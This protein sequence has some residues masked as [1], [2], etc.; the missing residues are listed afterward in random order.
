MKKRLI[1]I[2]SLVIILLSGAS[3]NDDAARSRTT[4][5]EI[6]NM[7]TTKFNLIYLAIATIVL[8]FSARTQAQFTDSMGTGWNNAMSAS[9]S[10]MIWNSIFYRTPGKTGTTRS[11]PASPP[12]NQVSPPSPPTRAKVVDE[13]SLRFKGTGTNIKTR[14]L[15]DQLGS[16]QAERDQYFTLM[17]AVLQA[18]D[19]RAAAA[20]KKNDISLALSYFLGENLRIYR[21]QPDLSDAQFLQL[22][23]QIASAL[24]ESGAA[25]SFT[26]RQ[27]QEMYETLVAY[28][29]ITQYGYEQGLKAGDQQITQGY[30]KVAGQNLQT[31]TKM[32]PDDINLGPNSASADGSGSPTVQPP[33]ALASGETVDIYQ[34]RSD[35]TENDVR[36]DQIYKG[37]RFIFVGTVM[38]VSSAHYKTTGKDETGR[39]IYS[40]MGPSARLHNAHG[41]VIGSDV[42]CFF[43]DG[44]QL[45]QL[46]GGQ[47]VTFEATVEGREAGSTNIILTDAVIR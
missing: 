3:L 18:F 42:Y 31:V 22:R 27:K 14:E 46:R 29:G 43:R 41:T 26:D 12:S 15:A 16:S 21:G 9:A 30:Q 47:V 6:T 45:A 44:N 32:S 20:G 35:Y 4:F 19:E 33:A 7:K 38:D 2:V 36:A 28:T 17:N 8:A 40:D 34:I 39:Y 11:K 37:K 25:K 13:T 24:S 1:W 5:W 10:T 23:D